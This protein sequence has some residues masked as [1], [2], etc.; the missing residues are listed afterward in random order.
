MNGGD[1]HYSNEFEGKIGDTFEL[2]TSPDLEGECNVFIGWYLETMK[3]GSWEY[4]LISD[5]QTFTYEITGNES[6]S[7]YAVWT[8]GENPFVKT[9]VDIRVEN[10]FVNYSTGEVVSESFDN[11]YSAISVSNMGRVTFFD[12]PTDE[13]VYKAWDVAYRYEIDDEVQHSIALSYEDEYD[14]YPAQYWVDDPQYS[15][16]DGVINV[17][18]INQ[19]SGGLE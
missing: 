17:T 13:T 7:L 5:S 11:A 1:G 14:Y 9:Y 6:G 8:T 12:D 10:G 16:L 19:S 15:Y 4:V 3:N 2:T 18:G